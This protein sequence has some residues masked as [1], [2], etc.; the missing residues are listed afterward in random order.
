VKGTMTNASGVLS[1]AL[2]IDG[3]Q[4]AISCGEAVSLL[5]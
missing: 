4:K 5:L 1:Q 3:I 2:A